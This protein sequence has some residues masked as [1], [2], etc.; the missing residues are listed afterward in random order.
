MSQNGVF[1]PFRD[2]D[3]SAHDRM[4]IQAFGENAEAAT[5][6]RR[7][8]GESQIRMLVD[9]RRPVA[10]VAYL[11]MAQYFGGRAVDCTAVAS[12]AVDASHR[13]KGHSTRLMAEALRELRQRGTPLTALYAATEEVYRRVGS[14][15]AGQHR[16]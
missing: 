13:G 10:T 14:E 2:E 5:T 15:R 8:I 6:Y 12:V 3:R 11:D 16:V 9:D 7:V 1:R 4:M